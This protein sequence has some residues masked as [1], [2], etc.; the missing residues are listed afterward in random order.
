[1]AGK[2]DYLEHQLL[3]HIFRGSAIFAAPANTFI[4]LFTTLP[5]DAGAGG[6]ETT[7]GGYAR[8]TVASVAGSW[9]DPSIAT[10]GQVENLAKIV[11]PVNIGPTAPLITGVGIFDA[12]SGGNLLY[13]AD[14]TDFT[15]EILMQP[16]FHENQLVVSED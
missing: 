8:V 16:V 5:N 10:Q 2:A 3:N 9:K 14:I 1:M 12:V 13:W 4:G 11:F 15:V 6:V 7:Y